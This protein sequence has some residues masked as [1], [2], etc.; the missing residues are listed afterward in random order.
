MPRTDSAAP[1]DASPQGGDGWAFDAI[2]TRWR[3][4]TIIC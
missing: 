3:I 2:G 4:D 1:A